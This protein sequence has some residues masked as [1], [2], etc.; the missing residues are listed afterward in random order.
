[1]SH[2]TCQRLLSPA[3]FF[4]LLLWAAIL[5]RPCEGGR[6]LVV[7]MEGSHWVNMNLLIRAL[8][9]RGHS[10]T[11]LRSSRSW[12]VKE[13]S[14]HYSSVTVAVSEGL[15]E[16]FAHPII[17]RLI[18][19]QRTNSSLLNFMGLHAEVFRAM[20]KAHQITCEMATNLFEDKDLVKRLNDSRFDLILTDPCIGTGI[21]L[22]QHLR[23]PLVYNVRWVTS[24][25]GHLAMAPSP[26]SYVPMTG[27]GFS[28]RMTF[29]ERTKNMLFYLLNDLHH[30]LRLLPQY[31]AVCDRYLEPKVDF[32][33][34]LQGA[35]L[36]LMRVDFVFEFPRPT[37]PNVVYMG[38]FHCQPAAPLPAALQRFVQSA[39]DH[40][41]IVM[42]LGTFVKELPADMTDAIAAAFA[43]LPQKVVWKHAAGRKQPP[44]SLG[45]NTLLVDWMPQN[46]LLGHPKVVLF[47]THGGTN[48][49]QEAIYHGVPVVGLPLYSDQY[50]NLVRIRERGAGIIL[51][52]N[53][54][55]SSS[56]L[57]A[58]REVLDKPRYRDNMRRLSRL[59]RD[60]PTKPL[61]S[62]LFWIE[63]VMRHKGA[64]HLRTE[65]YRL[66]WYSYRS[67]DMVMA[68]LSAVFA[69][70]LVAIAL[71]V[72]VVAMVRRLR[73]TLRCRGVKSKSD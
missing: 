47:V 48:G 7:P 69:M 22:A 29:T 39:G 51:P 68:L 20:E 58:L 54:V 4:F 67:V 64:A 31:Q 25:E 5:C 12:Y 8:H 55:D 27:M 19:A 49:I 41:V 60:Q 61:D 17:Q 43:Q 24:G 71:V 26:L 62:A 6:V 35:D 66:P 34:L 21:I 36:W 9:S 40:G 38:G 52:I 45:N 30:R 28:H 32:Y 2:S 11:V 72:A 15:D 56:F 13:A 23:L 57:H 44:S 73:L 37:M 16:D 42:S 1:M 3:L 65:S 14:P 53:L 46:D 50:D 18:Q 33:E 70:V 59:H 10:V 63:H